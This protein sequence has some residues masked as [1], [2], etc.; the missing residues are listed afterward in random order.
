MSMTWWNCERGV[1]SGLMPL[2]HETAIG[3]RVPPKCAPTSLVDLYGVLP[4]QA[5]PA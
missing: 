2:G 1:A 4:A 3:W 5:Q